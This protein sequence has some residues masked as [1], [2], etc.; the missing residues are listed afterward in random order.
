[1]FQAVLNHG[2]LN[3]KRICVVMRARIE[4]GVGAANGIRTGPLTGCGLG[5]AK[6]C[7]ERA[8]A[9]P[10]LEDLDGALL[11]SGACV[12]VLVVSDIPATSTS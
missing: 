9:D 3:V 11:N 5:D 10:F 1:M 6:L 7:G 12:R 8:M 4:N 2:K